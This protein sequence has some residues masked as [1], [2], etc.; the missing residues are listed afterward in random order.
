MAK[1]AP[2]PERCDHRYQLTVH[3]DAGRL[4]LFCLRC[5]TMIGELLA[6]IAATP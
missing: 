2:I 5:S 4:Y 1:P 6:K 3:H